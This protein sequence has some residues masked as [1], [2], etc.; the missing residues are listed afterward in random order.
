MVYLHSYFRVMHIT[1]HKAKIKHVDRLICLQ[2][3]LHNDLSDINTY[4]VLPFNPLSGK[5]NT[6]LILRNRQNIQ[7]VFFS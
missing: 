2:K 5:G 6:L 7:R 1:E 4:S 3:Q